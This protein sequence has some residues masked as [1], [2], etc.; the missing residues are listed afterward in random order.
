MA[1]SKPCVIDVDDLWPRDEEHRYR[2]YVRRGD[3]ELEL[4]GASSTM[5]GIGVAIEAQ[6]NDCKAV[7]RRLADLGVVG[8]LDTLA[9][10]PPATGE[11]IVQPWER[12]SE[13]VT[14]GPK[15]RL[16]KEK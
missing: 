8:I 4:L 14:F 9:H 3:D 7:G 13:P 2:L 10:D 5:A 6:H 15:P 12:S 1:R 11:W 16:V